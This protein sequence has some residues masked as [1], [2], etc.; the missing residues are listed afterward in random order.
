[1][2][3]MYVICIKNFKN[4]STADFER[5]YVEVTGLGLTDLGFHWPAL[6]ALAWGVEMYKSGPDSNGPDSNVGSVVL[7]NV[8]FGHLKRG[9]PYLVSSSSFSN[10]SKLRDPRTII[11]T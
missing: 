3:L 4:E 7:Q 8:R 9:L 5:R 11:L 2:K 6:S 1:M 10:G